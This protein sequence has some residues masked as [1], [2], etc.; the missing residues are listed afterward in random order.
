MRVSVINKV[1]ITGIFGMATSAMIELL[2]G[3]TGLGMTDICDWICNTAGVLIGI[4]VFMRYIVNT[5]KIF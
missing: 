3:I 4:V 5:D 2:Q 1:I